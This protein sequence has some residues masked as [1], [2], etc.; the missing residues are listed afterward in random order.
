MLTAGH[1][2]K[3]IHATAQEYLDW[4]DV[5]ASKIPEGKVGVVIFAVNEQNDAFI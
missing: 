2:F 4:K 5:Y 3:E 1:F